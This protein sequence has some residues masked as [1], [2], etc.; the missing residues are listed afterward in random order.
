MTEFMR[1]GH[2]TQVVWNETLTV[3][4]ATQQCTNGIGNAA[5]VEPYLTVCNYGGPGEYCSAKL[6]D[7]ITNATC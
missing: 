7:R 2:F 1:W 5:G 6:I 4:C 3:G